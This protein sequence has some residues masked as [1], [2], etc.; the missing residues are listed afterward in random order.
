MSLTPYSAFVENSI[1]RNPSERLGIGRRLTPFGSVGLHGRI[2][3]GR[4]G[5][6]RF[7]TGLAVVVAVALA[8][9]STAQAAVYKGGIKGEPDA[10]LKLTVKKT[11]GDR[12]VTRVGFK[13]IP[14][15]C[16]G[17]KSSTGGDASAG[18]PDS[19]GIEING[20]KFSGPWDFGKI[21]GKVRGGGKIAGT[22]SIKTDAGG[23][24][25]ECKSGK[26][27]YVVRS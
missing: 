1:A 18:E 11:M 13:K 4:L 24:L 14:V 10:S 2:N 17:G 6:M 27:D 8:G 7:A 12:Y 19:P 15:R 3:A 5:V 9:A 23:S 20:R 21:S 16:D 26:L 22:V 25:G